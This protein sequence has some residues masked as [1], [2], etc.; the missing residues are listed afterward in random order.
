MGDVT[1][2]VTGI[3]EFSILV[4]E[5]PGLPLP[6]DGPNRITPAT[7]TTFA[8]DTVLM[9]DGSTVFAVDLQ[10]LAGLLSQYLTPFVPSLKFN[11][12]RNSQYLSLTV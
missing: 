1:I 5:T 8:A 9:S 3:D 6:V 2:D 7:L 11:D 12:S 10:T 4:L